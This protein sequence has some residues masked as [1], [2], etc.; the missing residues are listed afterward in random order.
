MIHS[1]TITIVGNEHYQ[2]GDVVYI[3]NR[4]MLYY[5]SSVSHNFSFD[6]GNFQTTLSLTYGRAL[7]EYIPTPLD[8]IGKGLLANNRQS[9]GNVSVARS[10]GGS[11]NALHLETFFVPEY[12]S[13]G[14]PNIA[15]AKESFLIS[16]Q[17]SNLASSIVKRA[18]ARINRKD[19]TTSRIEIRVYYL[20]SEELDAL[21]FTYIKAKAFSKW[22]YTLLSSEIDKQTELDPTSKI[23]PSKL[24]RVQPIKINPG[25]EL[26]EREEKLLRFPSGRAWAGSKIFINSDGV[27][28]PLNAIDVFFVSEKS[29]YGDQEALALNDTPISVA[30]DLV[31]GDDSPGDLF[32]SLV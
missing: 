22:V 3:N 12:A 30:D 9:F 2:V 29:L 16:E 5:I 28:I 26:N 23:E 15:N 11:G 18:A 6:T 17:N 10:S 8:V 31:I 19:D 20:E 24:F 27:E 4:N 14:V 13:I 32:G 21:N 25:T 1:G 7:G